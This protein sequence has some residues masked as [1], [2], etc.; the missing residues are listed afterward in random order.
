M[1]TRNARRARSVDAQSFMAVSHA[2]G[3]RYTV[4]HLASDPDSDYWMWDFRF[5][6]LDF[7]DCASAPAPCYIKDFVVPGPG[8]SPAWQL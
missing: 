1:R 7:A 5:G 4:N 3:N 6:G 2:Q 8:L